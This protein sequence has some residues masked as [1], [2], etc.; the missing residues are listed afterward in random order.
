MSLPLHVRVA[1]AVNL[2]TC[3]LLFT[4]TANPPRFTY[5]P[6]ASSARGAYSVK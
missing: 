2:A 6:V 1:Y 4:Q 5:T 3:D